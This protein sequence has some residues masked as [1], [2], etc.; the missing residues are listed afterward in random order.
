MDFNDENVFRDLITEYLIHNCYKNTAK[1]FLGEVK[2]LNACSA[3]D[4]A[5]TPVNGNNGNDKRRRS[6]TTTTT[7]AMDIDENDSDANDADAYT[8]ALLD[9]RK[10][11]YDAILSGNIPRAFDVIKQHFPTLAMH[12]PQYPQQEQRTES[13]TVDHENQSMSQLQYILFKLRCQQFVEIVRSSDE[14]EAIR[15]A[16]THLRPN[17]KEFQDLTNEVA[18]LI[19]YRDPH[20][21]K[22]SHLLS[23]E[24]RLQLA[25]EVNTVVLSLSNLRNE[26]SFERLYKQ[27]ELIESELAKYKNDGLTSAEKPDQERMGM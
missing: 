9:A 7:D 10:D 6:N 25:D 8:W 11:L 2:K 22:S 1:A 18:S 19:A 23:Q 14:V 4:I 16:Q 17:N 13:M 21:S 12:D 27:N 5:S 24:R 3:S 26:S 20:N 15:F